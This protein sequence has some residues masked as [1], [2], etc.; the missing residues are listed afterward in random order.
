MALFLQPKKI[1]TRLLCPAS[2]LPPWKKFFRLFSWSTLLFQTDWN[3]WMI[4]ADKRSWNLEI[5]KG[6][7]QTAKWVQHVSE[8][9]FTLTCLF[10]NIQGVLAL[11]DFWDLEK[12]ALAKI[13]IRRESKGEFLANAIFGCFISLMR[14]RTNEIKQH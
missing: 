5:I 2:I 14:Y 6:C 10:T 3:H 7:R 1:Q 9:A 8:V 13:R 11:C 4:M 12:F